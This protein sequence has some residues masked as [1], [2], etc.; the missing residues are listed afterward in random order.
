[1]SITL[2]RAGMMRITSFASVVSVSWIRLLCAHDVQNH[3][4]GGLVHRFLRNRSRNAT[5]VIRT[6]PRS[7]KWP[8]S[9]FRKAGKACAVCRAVRHLL[10]PV[11]H[12]PYAGLGTID[13]FSRRALAAGV[14][15]KR[16]D[17]RGVCACLGRTIHRLR[18]V[19]EIYRL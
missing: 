11:Y 1:M 2:R 14:F 16:S 17:C 8:K 7:K 3:H 15:A 4:L 13:H 6:C 12:Y 18:T 9:R 5:D 19:H 10:G